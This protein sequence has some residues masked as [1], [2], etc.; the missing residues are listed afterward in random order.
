V[1]RIKG[2]GRRNGFGLLETLVATALIVF[3]FPAIWLLMSNARQAKTEEVRQFAEALCNNALERFGVNGGGLLPH[4]TPESDQPENYSSDDLA[5]IPE[6][7]RELGFAGGAELVRKHQI[8]LRVCLKHQE[9]GELDLLVSRV[10]W[11][12]NRAEMSL[13]RGRTVLANVQS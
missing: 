3:T 2:A 1:K 7:T 5:G 6:L 9:V 12:E 10:T 4:L 11:V 8:R 13:T